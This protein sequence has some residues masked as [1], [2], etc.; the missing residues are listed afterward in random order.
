MTVTRITG[1]TSDLRRKVF[2]AESKPEMGRLQ[3]FRE[4]SAETNIP[5]PKRQITAN[6]KDPF[7]IKYQ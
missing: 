5:I 6:M 3:R 2:T 4:G 7:S 1:S